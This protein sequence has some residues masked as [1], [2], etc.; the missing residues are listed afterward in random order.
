MSSADF[1]VYV[2]FDLDG[3]PL[4]VGK[5]RGAR[6]ERL[7]A[8]SGRNPHFLRKAQGATREGLELPR[9]KVRTDLGEMEAFEVEKAL[10]AAIGR[11]ANGEGPLLNL[12]AGGEGM[13]S[14][15]MSDETKRKISAARKGYK[16]SP[17]VLANRSSLRGQS[18]PNGFGDAVAARLLGGHLSA[19]I[20]AKIS[21]ANRGR[22]LPPRPAMT[23]ERKENLRTKN[24]GKKASLATR[25]RMSEAHKRLWETRQCRQPAK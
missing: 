22:K 12:T 3:S 17:Q 6:W 11:R 19:E 14:V 15:A 20:R 10:I 1:Y 7:D 18:K 13:L 25:A 21:A 8:S 5:G 24:L 9:V 23:A 2:Y 4:Y 16:V